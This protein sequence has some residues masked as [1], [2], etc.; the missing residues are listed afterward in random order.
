MKQI[1][2]AVSFCAFMAS[3]MVLPGCSSV[4]DYQQPITELNESMNYSVATIEQI[5]SELTAAQNKRWR[6]LISKEEAFLLEAED[7][8]ALGTKL[9]SVVVIAKG[10]DKEQVFPVTSMMPNAAEALSGLKGYTEGLK[11]IVDADTAAS[12]ISSANAALAS[13][14]K[15]ELEIAKANG[16]S[17]AASTIEAY[18]SPLSNSFSWLISQY[19]DRGKVKALAVATKRA[20]PAIESLANYYDIAASVSASL[21][22]SEALD[23][24]LKAQSIF[25]DSSVKNN[26]EIN[27]YLAAASSY[28][29]VLKAGSS[30]PMKKFLIAHTA[31][32]NALNGSENVSLADAIA[33]IKEFKKHSED[34]KGLVEAFIQVAKEKETN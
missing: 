15:I 26:Q 22:A 30:E 9:C 3:I 8:C 13:A 11:A 29:T 6:E 19:I 33:A 28:D 25:D 16:R 20:Q 24:F 2:I 14:S 32:N 31:L 12:I 4:A 23:N 27:Q 34:F 7:S 18:S 10:S 21:K 5:D 1:S 17:S